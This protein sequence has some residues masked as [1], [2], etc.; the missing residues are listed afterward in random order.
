MVVVVLMVVVAALVVVAVVVV[1][2]EQMLHLW[3]GALSFRPES[4]ALCPV[5]NEVSSF[6]HFLE[7]L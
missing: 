1:V 2:P 7:S 3:S 6:A 4:L 5:V